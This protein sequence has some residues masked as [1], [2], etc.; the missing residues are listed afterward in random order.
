MEWGTRLCW[1]CNYKLVLDAYVPVETPSGEVLVHQSC[2][3][4]VEAEY[5]QVTAQIRERGRHVE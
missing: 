4:F 5:R 3:P 1:W 2:K